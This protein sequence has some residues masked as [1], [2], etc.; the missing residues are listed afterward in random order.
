MFCLQFLDLW[1]ATKDP[2]AQPIL[3]LAVP[4]MRQER[5][6]VVGEAASILSAR[7]PDPAHPE[8]PLMRLLSARQYYRSVTFFIHYIL[9]PPMAKSFAFREAIASQFACAQTRHSSA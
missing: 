9:L 7:R 8:P 6:A 5:I 1:K 2:F 4:R 3:D